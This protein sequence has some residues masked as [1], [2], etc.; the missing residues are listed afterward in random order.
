MSEEADPAAVFACAMSLHDACIGRAATD[1]TFH[2]SESYHGGDEFL[3]QMMR[4]G[5]LFEAWACGHVAFGDLEDVWPYLLQDRFGEACLEVLGP[6][7]MALF[8][9]DDCLRVAMEL[10]LPLRVDGGLPVPFVVEV[11]HPVEAAG[12]RRLR[13]QTLREQLGGDPEFIPFVAG[14]DPFDEE[15]GPVL[16][17]IFGVGSDGLLQHIAD[18]RT[19]PEARGLLL[20]LVPGIDLPEEAITESRAGSG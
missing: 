5:N 10:R 1:P 16:F 8:D 14:D 12:F 3:R 2:V 20:A 11:D 7:Q 9:A 13:I 15:L 18:R 19:Y 4:V 6:G 17:G